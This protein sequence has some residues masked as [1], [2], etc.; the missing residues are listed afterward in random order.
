MVNAFLQL[1]RQ[2]TNQLR[3]GGENAAEKTF[4]PADQMAALTLAALVM[5][6]SVVVTELLLHVCDAP[7]IPPSVFFFFCFCF[8]KHSEANR[9]SEEQHR[10]LENVNSGIIFP[11]HVPPYPTHLHL[12]TKQTTIDR[13][14]GMCGWWRETRF[15]PS[16]LE[17]DN[18]SVSDNKRKTFCCN[19]WWYTPRIIS[20]WIYLIS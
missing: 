2:K 9:T 16:K 12:V 10:L 11:K 4:I 7:P 13:S 20:H 17:P 5:Q 14:G 3:H 1:H 8:F 18:N 19:E 15:R 6:L